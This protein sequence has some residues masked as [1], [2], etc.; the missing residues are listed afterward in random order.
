M[1]G[2]HAILRRKTQKAHAHYNRTCDKF[3]Y[4]LCT[5]T[6]LSTKF[7]GIVQEKEKLKKRYLSV[8]IVLLLAFAVS[9]AFAAGIRLDP[10]GSYYGEAV[11]QSSPATFNVY[12]QNGEGN[13]PHLFMAMPESSM[14]ATVTVT[15]PGLAT[16]VTVT[17]WTLETDGG[18]VP[19]GCEDGS[20]YTVASIK[21][22]LVTSEN[23]YWAF[24]P[25]LD[26]PLSKDGSEFTITLVSSKPEMLIY[27][28]AKD[29]GATLFSNSVPPTQPGFVVPDLAP[30][31]MGLA[32]LS[33]LGLYAFKRRRSSNTVPV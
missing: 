31:L 3:F 5:A 28:L 21:S 26:G 6:F 25:F 29:D 23:I 15:W 9:P 33:A 13:D 10:H 20:D 22:H 18:K 27:V 12:L 11:M 30:V 14:P 2:Y 32:S 8:M 17:S 16:P 19:S 4:N 7:A 24:I 1:F